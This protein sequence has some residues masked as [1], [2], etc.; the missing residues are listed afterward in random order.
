MWNEGAGVVPSAMWISENDPNRFIRPQDRNSIPTV[1]ADR[2]IRPQEKKAGGKQHIDH[3]CRM[4][5]AKC[6]R[7]YLPCFSPIELIADGYVNRPPA[8]N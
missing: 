7:L 5:M 4:R 3:E 1:G 8:M 2:R 6:G